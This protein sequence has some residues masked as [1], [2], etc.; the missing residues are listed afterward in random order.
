MKKNLARLENKTIENDLMLTA[1]RK[2]FKDLET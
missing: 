2:D 1:L